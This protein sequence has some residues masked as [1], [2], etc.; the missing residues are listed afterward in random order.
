MGV[1]D[2]D[3]IAES[4]NLAGSC[5]KSARPNVTPPT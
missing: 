5:L 4:P 2:F 3:R 1:D